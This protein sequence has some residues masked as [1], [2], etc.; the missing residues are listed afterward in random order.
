MSKSFRQKQRRKKQVRLILTLFV[1]CLLIALGL[2]GLRS[3]SANM[4]ST[5]NQGY[6]PLDTHR[7]PSRSDN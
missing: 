2:V 5:Y 4:K 6:Q 1:A 3:C 7:V